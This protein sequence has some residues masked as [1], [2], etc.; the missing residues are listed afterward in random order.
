M[1]KNYSILMSVY[2]KDNTEYLKKSI[3]SMLTQ[4]IL[5]DDFVIV[6]DGVLTDALNAVL[7]EYAEKYN[8][9]HLIKKRNNR[10][11]GAALNIGL[12]E[13][14]NELIARMDSDDI[15]LPERC[16][17]ELKVFND[18]LE[19]GIVGSNIVQFIESPENVVGTKIMPNTTKDIWKYGKRRNPFNHPTVMY[20]KSLILSAGGYQETIRGEDFALFTKLVAEGIKGE[21]IPENLVMY[22]ADENQFKRRTSWTD[23]KAVIE[24]VYRNWKRKYCSIVDL[25]CVV[26]IQMISFMIPKSIGKVMYQKLLLK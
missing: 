8:F 26:L 19:I 3:D 6:E 17:K 21:N 16:E 7:E 4:T 13:C 11:L 18:N 24:V 12:M 15:S 25:I 10:G 14:K 1:Y 2:K 22:R 5:T 9:I 20:K 23:T